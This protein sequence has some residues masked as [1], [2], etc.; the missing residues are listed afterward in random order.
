MEEK[1]ARHQEKLEKMA[2]AL[3][4]AIFCSII[5]LRFREEPKNLS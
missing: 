2:N 4:F 1:E 5:Y 3:T